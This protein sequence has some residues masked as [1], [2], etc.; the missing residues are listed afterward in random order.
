MRPSTC[1]EESERELKKRLLSL[2]C[3]ATRRAKEE[4]FTS[5]E[6]APR[7]PAFTHTGNQREHAEAE[8]KEEGKNP[9]TKRALRN[10]GPRHAHHAPVLL[11]LL[12]ETW[13]RT[14]AQHLNRQTPLGKTRAPEDPLFLL[15]LPLL[16]F[17]LL[18]FAT[19][20]RFRL[21]VVRVQLDA[22]N[23]PYASLLSLLAF[24]VLRNLRGAPLL[25]TSLS[26]CGDKR[27]RMQAKEKARWKETDERE[28]TKEMKE[29]DTKGDK[30]LQQPG[31]G[32]ESKGRR[33]KDKEPLES[34]HQEERSRRGK[35]AD[36][37]EEFRVKRRSRE[38]SRGSGRK[39]K[40]AHQQAEAR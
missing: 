33:D 3:T 21:D 9:E 18:A 35:T 24:E 37:P 14:K 40:A 12:L 29:K 16:F 20:E 34:P 17:F 19:V 39:R 7:F 28:K 4:N 25:A 23:P 31:E 13:K 1:R 11:L 8:E 38:I 27:R 10:P 22:C 32:G 30:C 6:K 2:R 26:V 5:D 15:L 36:S